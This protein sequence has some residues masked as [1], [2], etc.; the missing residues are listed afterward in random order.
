[1]PG[2][3]CTHTHN[4]HTHAHPEHSHP[5]PPAA[6]DAVLARTA[7]KAGRTR[8]SKQHARARRQQLSAARTAHTA[9]HP[10]SGHGAGSTGT[11][12]VGM[13]RPCSRSLPLPSSP[14]VCPSTLY[15]ATLRGLRGAQPQALVHGWKHAWVPRESAEGGTATQALVHGWKHAWVPRESDEGGHCCVQPTHAR[16]WSTLKCLRCPD[17]GNP[18]FQMR[19]TLVSSHTKAHTKACT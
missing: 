16:S 6:C 15:A 10:H 1:M 19:R 13:K 5:A 4:T 18:T 3:P 11:Q 14:V 8:R 7:F 2:L 9:L 17:H 12:K